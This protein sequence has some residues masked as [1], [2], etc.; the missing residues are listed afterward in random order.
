MPTVK[1]LTMDNN[2][3]CQILKTDS[4]QRYIVNDSDDWQFLFNNNSA[5]ANSNQ[6]LKLSA[7]L[8]TNNLNS[9]RFIGYLYN[10]T[11]GTVDSSGSV[12]FKIYRIENILS[13]QWN[14]VLLTTING[15]LM[16]NNYFFGS[17]LINNL[18]GANLDGETT[19]MIEGTATRLNRTYRDRLYVNHLGVY[20]SI[21]RLRSD[22]DFLDI[23]KLDE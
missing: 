7:E 9:I 12:T 5:L 22:V 14:E 13:P 10:Q 4:S 1:L 11:T 6:I 15:S 17:E 23:T 3:D 8:N 21:I 2:E 20:D 16:S 19:L 18:T